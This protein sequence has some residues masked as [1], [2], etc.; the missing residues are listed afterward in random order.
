VNPNHE[1][2][3]A[4]AERVA[5][6]AEVV[7]R[8]ASDEVGMRRAEFEGDHTGKRQLLPGSASDREVVL[9]CEI[10][11]ARHQMVGKLAAGAGEFQHLLVR[12]DHMQVR[13]SQPGRDTQQPRL[14]ADVVR[15]GGLEVDGWNRAQPVAGHAIR[16]PV[17]SQVI[18][19]LGRI[20]TERGEAPPRPRTTA[21]PDPRPSGDREKR[22]QVARLGSVSR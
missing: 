21:P 4:L 3:S 17:K 8:D 10:P 9:K 14:L 13:A 5:G 2:E 22:D 15:A 1:I 16:E 18:P 20:Q 11:L 7:G 6:V 12:L 19:N